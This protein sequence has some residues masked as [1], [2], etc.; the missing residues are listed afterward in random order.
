[1]LGV[2]KWN[3]AHIFKRLKEENFSIKFLFSRIFLFLNIKIPIKFKF[4]NNLKLV[5]HPASIAHT[6]YV[7]SHR[8]GKLKDIS[9]IEKFVKNGDICID[10]GA[11]IG[12]LSLIMAKSSYPNGLVISIE[13]GRRL[14]S[15]LI[16]NIVLNKIDNI[17]PL[18][19]AIVKENKVVEFFEYYYAD[20]FSSFK[21]IKKFPADSYK[22][23]TMRLD[24]LL[25]CLNLNKIDFL[26]IDVEGLEFEVIESLGDFIEKV[27]Y[28]YFE[29][30]EKNLL[31]YNHNKG[32]VLNL[33]HQK[34]FK[35]YKL[36]KEADII[37]VDLN[38]KLIED[39]NYLAINNKS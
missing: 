29:L 2:F 38:D 33:L 14:F 22:V 6:F 28:I 23:L 8:M 11:N 26:K 37:P 21:K 7:K 10:V 24:F 31:N 17:V 13:P 30:N 39:D 4:Y 3:I 16:E 36:T 12:H 25:F 20:N 15:Y 9:V 5:L 34:G 18:N 19:I 32:E 35:I 27:K 1:M